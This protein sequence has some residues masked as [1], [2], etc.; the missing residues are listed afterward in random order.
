M[1]IPRAAEGEPRTP[2][3]HPL[4]CSRCD[5]RSAVWVGDEPRCGRHI[6]ESLPASVRVSL[7][8]DRA[9]SARLIRNSNIETTTDVSTSGSSRKGGH[10]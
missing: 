8:V 2:D 4:P 5:Q 6:G 1:L 9:R 7:S 10:P 3:G